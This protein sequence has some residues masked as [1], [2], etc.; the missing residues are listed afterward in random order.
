[1]KTPK[2]LILLWALGSSSADSIIYLTQPDFTH[3]DL[4]PSPTI[5]LTHSKKVISSNGSELANLE[6]SSFPKI[7]LVTFKSAG[8]LRASTSSLRKTKRTRTLLSEEEKILFWPFS[9]LSGLVK[10]SKRFL[11]LLVVVVEAGFHGYGISS[12]FNG[13]FS[14]ILSLFLSGE[15]H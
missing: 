6:S 7:P 5:P 4:K 15:G 14:C 3:L 12:F 9:L 11:L 13:G 8:P 1:M 10:H 2:K